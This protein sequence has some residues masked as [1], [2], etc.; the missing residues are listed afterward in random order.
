MLR[1][2]AVVAGLVLF[3]AACGGENPSPGQGSSTQS[4]QTTPSS[5]VPSTVVGTPTTGATIVTTS[6]PE[7]T[8][9]ST[10]PGSTPPSSTPTPTNPTDPTATS[11]GDPVE[12]KA[13]PGDLRAEAVDINDQGVI[14]GY[15]RGADLLS[16]RGVW[17]PAGSSDPQPL[18]DLVDVGG[19]APFRVWPMWI[20]DDGQAFVHTMEIGEAGDRLDGTE[21]ILLVDTASGT[22]I[23]FVPSFGR[24]LWDLAGLNALGQ[25]AGTM[26]VGA[27]EPPPD[28]DVGSKPITHAFLWDPEV[29]ETVDL[30]VPPG[31]ESSFA[32]G[33]ND[34]G[35]VVGR[36]DDRPF[37]WD[38]TTG[39][40]RELDSPSED[41]YTVAFDIND[42]GQ[43]VGSTEY[44][45][46][47]DGYT[48]QALLWN[49]A[50]GETSVL[51]AG[52]ARLINDLGQVL[53]QPLR[54]EVE[55]H[56][57]GPVEVLDLGSGTGCRLQPE[58]WD[59]RAINDVGQ[60]IGN[61]FDGNQALVWT[62]VPVTD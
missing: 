60:I 11:C 56:S 42:L 35:Y 30:G 28:S 20:N 6:P 14:V 41:A 61:A 45:D 26:V 8:R 22:T 7:T 15:S 21:R 24:S 4:V 36:S 3:V 16:A 54:I 57:M 47:V 23:E 13:L 50:T 49:V 43:A 18:E 52:S 2:R 58:T 34:L 10:T 48:Q 12:L 31:A 44:G 33:L 1:V 5:V 39:E 62:V 19:S 37:V 51:G 40:I 27:T 29:G 53:F 38:P 25:V 32:Y 9:P 59:I 55:G 17:W 46:D